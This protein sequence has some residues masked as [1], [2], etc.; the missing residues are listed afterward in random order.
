MLK[1]SQE[2]IIC[3]IT[4]FIS[5]TFPHTHQKSVDIT[6]A[7]FEQGIVDSLGVLEIV[8]FIQ[9]SFE[10]YVKDEDIIEDNF[11]SIADIAT[12]VKQSLDEA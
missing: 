8:A 7:L 1:C 5:A 9:N 6:D 10:I 4:D 3:K 12:Y 2:E 11:S